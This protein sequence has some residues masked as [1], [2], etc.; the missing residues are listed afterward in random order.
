M[1]SSNRVVGTPSEL[2]A[3]ADALDESKVS[4]VTL[5]GSYENAKKYGVSTEALIANTVAAADEE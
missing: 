1:A 5:D 4:I 3:V 2:N